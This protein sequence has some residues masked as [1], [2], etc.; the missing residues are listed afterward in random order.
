M[1]IALV[2]GLLL[3]VRLAPNRL[4]SALVLLPAGSLRERAEA[5]TMQG[6]A[7]WGLGR[8]DDAKAAW[9]GA[10]QR[11]DE[12]GDEKA[13]AGVHA[14]LAHLEVRNDKQPREEPEPE[15]DTA[16]S[17]SPVR[18]VLAKDPA[19]ESQPTSREAGGTGM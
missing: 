18:E 15:P 7:A 14:R 2:V 4:G 9:K 19:Q 1:A 11:Y 8:I 5:L 13:A 16:A 3:T 12:L 6:Q 17:D 10:G